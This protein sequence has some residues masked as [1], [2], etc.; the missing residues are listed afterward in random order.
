[1]VAVADQLRLLHVLV[2][3]CSL[4]IALSV[5][6]GSHLH[7]NSDRSGLHTTT[8]MEAQ[9]STVTSMRH[10]TFTGLSLLGDSGMAV[11]KIETAAPCT[12][13]AMI[14]LLRRYCS[15]DCNAAPTTLILALRRVSSL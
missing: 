6:Y 7:T 5:V 1:M 9:P 13:R 3:I 10:C 4:L 14:A 12:A 8:Y 11:F 15:D 2:H